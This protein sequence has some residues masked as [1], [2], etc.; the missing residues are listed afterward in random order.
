MRYSDSEMYIEK[1][2]RMAKQFKKKK[3]INKKDIKNFLQQQNH[4]VG[5]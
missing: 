5:E 4:Y 2:A 3:K 1:L